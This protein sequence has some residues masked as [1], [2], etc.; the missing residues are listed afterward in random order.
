MVSAYKR[1]ILLGGFEDF[2]E[3][4]IDEP[5]FNRWSPVQTVAESKNNVEE[6]IHESIPG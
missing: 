5:G 2:I 3:E 6:G 1:P 4:V